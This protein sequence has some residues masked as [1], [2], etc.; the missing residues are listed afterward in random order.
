M[1]SVSEWSSRDTRD[2][3]HQPARKSFSQL[4]QAGVVSLIGGGT[5]LVTALGAHSR[6][7]VP[8][9]VAGITLIGNGLLN[10]RQ[11]LHRSATAKG[12][13]A[14]EG[15]H[16]ET[17]ITLETSPEKI[18]RVWRDL[19]SLPN[20][21]RHLRS[22][23]DDG[24]GRSHWV[25]HGPLGPIE[26]DAEIVTEHENQLLAW[27]SL[28]GSALATAGS[29]R[30]QKALGGRGTILRISLKYDPPGGRVTATIANLLGRGLETDVRDDLR[31]FKQLMETGEVATTAGQPTGQCLPC[32]KGGQR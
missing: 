3:R 19:E 28:P 10:R 12:V 29:V 5:L 17:A 13:R 2:P 6:L 8:L 15:V 21:L 14:R 30:L 32:K 1:S 27:Q 7:R 25:A 18:Y 22:V 31:K 24:E 23:R 26:W 20:V 11:D 16:F 9:G 4:D